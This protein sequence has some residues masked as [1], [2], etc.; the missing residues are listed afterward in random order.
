MVEFYRSTP[1]DCNGSSASSN[2]GQFLGNQNPMCG[3]NCSVG[4]GPTSPLRGGSTNNIYI[5]PAPDKL[6]FNTATLFAAA[7]CIPAILS[8]ISMCFK[9]LEINWKSRFGRDEYDENADGSSEEL[10]G[11]NTVEKGV[12]NMIR[13]WLRAL[14][15]PVYAAAILAILILGEM[16]FFSAQVRFQTEPISSI[17]G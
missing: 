6:T 7:C 5:I 13:L 14:E 2:V 8:L 17:G 15:I 1:I 3:F 4:N 16:N 9:I 12:E 11:A 10:D